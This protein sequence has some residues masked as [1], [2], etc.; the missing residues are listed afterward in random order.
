[1]SISSAPRLMSTSSAFAFAIAG[2]SSPSSPGTRPRSSPPT[3]EAAVCNTLKPFHPSFTTPAARA[4]LARLGQHSNAVRP[5]ESAGTD[6]HHWLGCVF[7]QS[8]PCLRERLW[9]SAQVIVF[10]SQIG[11]GADDAYRRA[12][13]EPA[14]ANARVEDGRLVARVGAN[15]ENSVS[16]IDTGDR[17]VEKIGCAAKLRMQFRAI[18]TAVDI[19][20]AELAE[21]RLERE[22]FFDRRQVADDCP[23]P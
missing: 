4:A 21:Q 5:S 10:V 9:S 17:R 16:L 22:H 18:L 3:R 1:M 11:V 2:A 19:G 14:L 7:R 13:L 15:D 12:A 8:I 20:R 23:D 6:N